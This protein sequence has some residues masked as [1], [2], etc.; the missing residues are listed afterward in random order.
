MS[1]KTRTFALH[2]VTNA[3]VDGQPRKVTLVAVVR[4]QD[5]KDDKIDMSIKYVGKKTVTTIV[6]EE[7]LKNIE[8]TISFGLAVVS[9]VDEK[10]H[11]KA[12]EDYDKA[13]KAKDKVAMAAASKY[14]DLVSE[15][16]GIEIATGKALKPKSALATITN[17]TRFFNH[18]LVKLML[19][20]KLKH[21][22]QDPDNFIR[23][24]APKVAAE[25]TQTKIGFIQSKQE[26]QA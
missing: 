6:S 8:T 23:I 17:D 24:A 3:L 21:I 4:N 12:I 16:R 9:P 1:T 7:V 11:K 14:L 20:D 10:L 18:G 5:I 2:G 13:S 22:C 15:A 19:A 26:L 25:G